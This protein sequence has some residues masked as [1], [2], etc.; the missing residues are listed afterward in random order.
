MNSET[1][2]EEKIVKQFLNLIQADMTISIF[3]SNRAAF[4]RI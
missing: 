4:Y 2:M 3:F 1:K